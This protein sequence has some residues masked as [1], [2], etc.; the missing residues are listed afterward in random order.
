MKEDFRPTGDRLR[1]EGQGCVIS[2]HAV[3][4]SA[5]KTERDK[6][7]PGTKPCSLS[8][9]HQRN[10]GGTLRLKQWCS[11]HWIIAWWHGHQNQPGHS[12]HT[13][14]KAWRNLCFYGLKA[15]PQP[16]PHSLFFSRG[17]GVVGGNW[18]DRRRRSTLW[19]GACDS[20][21]QWPNEGGRWWD[22]LLVRM[23]ERLARGLSVKRCNHRGTMGRSCASIIPNVELTVHSQ[24]T[25]LKSVQ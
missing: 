4:Q 23:W 6:T 20:G 3:C 2:L 17:P 24:R 22:F 12:P 18:C 9:Q 1:S 16:R 5:L 8:L 10:S 13:G 11:K 21:L 14:T 25:A 7:R 15:L 19:M